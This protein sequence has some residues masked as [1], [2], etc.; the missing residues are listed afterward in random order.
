MG[1]GWEGG[2]ENI[3]ELVNSGGCDG[4]DGGDGGGWWSAVL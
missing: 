2:G 1:R 3:A 4:G